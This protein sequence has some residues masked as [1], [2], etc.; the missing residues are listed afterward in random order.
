MVVYYKG[1]NHI[2]KALQH[3]EL[4]TISC[5]HCGAQADVTDT[6]EDRITY[7]CSGCEAIIIQTVSPVDIKTKKAQKKK[8]DEFR[9]IQVRERSEKKKGDKQEG[10][11]KKEE[12]Q[13]NR[14]IPS[15]TVPV[16]QGA[17]KHKRVLTI[18]YVS[19]KGSKSTRSVEPYKLEKNRK[20][21]IVL[22]AYCHEGEGIRQFKLKGIVAADKSDYE[23]E[24]RWPIEDRL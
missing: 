3:Q 10:P 5:P 7:R 11:L 17:M 23:Y 18:E 22:W 6:K 20:G 1:K 12:S 14:D 24:P 8:R 16:I 13:E 21:E 19:S 2:S 15:P 4:G 9:A